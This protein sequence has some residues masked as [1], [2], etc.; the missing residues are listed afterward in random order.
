MQHTQATRWTSRER[1]A[2][3]AAVELVGGREA[4]DAADCTPR[5]RGV[6]SD[7]LAGQEVGAGL[8]VVGA[9]RELIVERVADCLEG[10]G[11]EYVPRVLEHVPA[12]HTEW[13]VV[14]NVPRVSEDSPS[15]Q[16]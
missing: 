11:L 3:D 12:Q 14:L 5:T 16:H 15:G 1:T 4:V 13:S 6:G 2:S 10:V 8:G 9:A 7:A